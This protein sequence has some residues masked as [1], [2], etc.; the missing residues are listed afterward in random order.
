[1]I[2]L[3]KVILAMHLQQIM[4]HLQVSIVNRKLL[5]MI[6]KGTLFAT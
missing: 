1:M 4:L 5:P 2:L 3:Q 6:L